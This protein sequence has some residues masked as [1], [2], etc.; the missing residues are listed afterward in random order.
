MNLVLHFKITYSFII[1]SRFK[2]IYIIFLI[3][4]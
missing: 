2:L 1:K 3:R 4:T